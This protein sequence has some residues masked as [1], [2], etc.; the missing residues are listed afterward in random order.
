[1]GAGKS[2]VGQ[3]L[4][5]LTQHQFFDTDV[6][7][8]SRCGASISWIFDIETEAGFRQREAKVI[9]ELSQQSPVILATGGG[10]I[11]TPSNCHHLAARGL[12]IYLTVP[13]EMQLDRALRR[14][15]HRPLLKCQDPKSRLAKLNAEREPIYQSLAKLTY[16]TDCWD[17]KAIAKKILSD[18]S[19]EQL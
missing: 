15:G 19:K 5:K 14:T 16:N 4:A 8:E 10:C 6:E 9:D 1:M 12:V 11:V 13:F 2:S 18:L 17:A 7:I 3:A